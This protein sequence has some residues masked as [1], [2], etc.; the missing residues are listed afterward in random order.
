MTIDADPTRGFTPRADEI[1][2]IPHPLG[3]ASPDAAPTFDNSPGMDAGIEVAGIQFLSGAGEE[4]PYQR[5]LRSPAKEQVDTSPYPGDQSLS[6]WWLRTQTDWSGGA[7]QEFMEPITEDGVNRRFWASAGIDPFTTPGQVSLLPEAVTLDTALPSPGPIRETLAR[8]NGGFVAAGGTTVRSYSWSAGT[9]PIRGNE[10]TAGG[11]IEHL[12]VAGNVLLLSMQ[13]KVQSMPLDGATAPV[14]RYTG[15]G[16]LT[17]VCVHVKNRTLVMAG[18]KVWEV[19]GNPDV[20]LDMATAAPVVDLH[21]PSWSW[22]GAANTPTSI[23]IVGNG[24]GT[25]AVMSLTVDPQSGNL[26]TLAA[27]AI[28]ATLPPGEQI[29]S[30]STYLGAF[31][32]VATTAGIRVGTLNS[33]GGLQYG[34]LLGSPPMIEGGAGFSMWDRFAQYPVTDA[35][36]D[37][38]GLVRIDL[39]GLDNDSRAPWATY[40]RIPEEKPVHAHVT[41]DGVSI[42]MLDADGQLWLS[43]P[44]GLLDEGWLETSLVRYGT[45]EPKNF[46]TVRVVTRPNVAGQLT[47][48]TVVDEV[49]GPQI[50]ALTKA[51]GPEGTFPTG[52]R[53]ALS[54]MGLRF[55]FTRDVAF[56]ALGP[57]LEAWSMKSLPAITDEGEVVTIPLLNFDFERTPRGVNVG[58]EGLAWARWKALTAQIALGGDITIKELNSGATYVATPVDVM[59]TQTAAGNRASG[60]GGI[61]DLQVREVE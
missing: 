5:R 52:N 25:G 1:G 20:N 6:D 23:L 61:I 21:D 46:S 56:G 32:V 53:R 9:T 15:A 4:H 54:Q 41:L 24:A 18:D 3:F 10:Q 55:K 39:S 2:P 57:V 51:T 42:V 28:V 27:P 29:V 48:H 33:S 16:A 47:V 12:A 34:P 35:G 30:V 44:G 40:T 17:P 8:F 43:A 14:D 60:F 26:P 49:L 22:V 31:A 13:G 45:L 7:G 19:P 36:D 58:R 37:R 59:F 50:G 38:G 11:D